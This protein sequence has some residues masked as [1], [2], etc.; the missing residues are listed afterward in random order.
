MISK[1]PFFEYEDNQ[2]VVYVE[3]ADKKYVGKID[4]PVYEPKNIKPYIL[5][6]YNTEKSNN[7]ID[8]INK[9]SLPKAE[10]EF[11]IQAS[12]RHIVFN[13]EKIADYYA[14]S[15]KEMQNLMEESALVIVDF[16]QAIENGFVQVCEELKKQYTGEYGN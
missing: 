16:N 3:S 5:E 10:K 6:L 9:S 1:N 7:L 14:H 2:G 13:Y 8:K 11:L 15:N 12:K 4:A